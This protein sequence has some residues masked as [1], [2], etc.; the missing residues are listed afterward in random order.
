MRKF[1]LVHDLA[2]EP[3]GTPLH[4]HVDAGALFVAK[5]PHYVGVLE[6][7]ADASFTI[8]P[9]REDWIGLHVRM[10]DLEGD[11]AVIAHIGGAVDGS[12]TAAGNGGI[13]P[14]RIDLRTGFKAVEKTH[15][16]T[17]SR[18]CLSFYFTGKGLWNRKDSVRAAIDAQ[19]VRRKSVGAP[20]VHAHLLDERIRMTCAVVL[21]PHQ[22]QRRAPPTRGPLR[23][24]SSSERRFRRLCLRAFRRADRQCTAPA[25]RWAAA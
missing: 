8:E 10:R 21:S 23:P 1:A 14:V 13:N 20:P 22:S 12:H 4:D 3:A 5:Y 25:H 24:Y 19:W 2:Q 18:Q 7:F 6:P 11:G 17:Y 15:R 9:V 16:A